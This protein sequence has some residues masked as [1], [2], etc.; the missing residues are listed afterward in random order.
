MSGDDKIEETSPGGAKPTEEKGRRGRRSGYR[1][2]GRYLHQVES[3]ICQ[4][5]LASR[6]WSLARVDS[7]QHQRLFFTVLERL[8]VVIVE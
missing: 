3:S 8:H 6:G 7:Q 1:H 4:R 5:F 2:Q